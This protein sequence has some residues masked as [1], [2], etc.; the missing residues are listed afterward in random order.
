MIRILVL[1]LTAVFTICTHNPGKNLQEKIDF[2]L[3]TAHQYDEFTGNV[4]VAN[5]GEIVYR[6]SFGFHNAARSF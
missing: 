4:L 5:K 6:K 1:L 2:I 3:E